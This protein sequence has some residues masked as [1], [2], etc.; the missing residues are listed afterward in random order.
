[1]DQELIEICIVYAPMVIGLALPKI[2]RRPLSLMSVVI[3]V[4]SL[5]GQGVHDRHFYI[6]FFNL[7]FLFGWVMR[8]IINLVVRTAHGLMAK[9]GRACSG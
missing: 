1:M 9:R 3:F 7:M 4:I 2:V 8:E 5:F 6:F